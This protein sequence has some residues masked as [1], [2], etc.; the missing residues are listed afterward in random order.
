M[1]AKSLVAAAAVA[2]SAIAFVPAEANAK[3]HWDVHIGVGVPAYPIYEGPAY[4]YEP[5]YPV[6][7]PR[8]HYYEP[9]YT[10]EAPRYRYVER[11]YCG[12]G[13]RAVRDAGFRG[14]D[15][16]DCSGPIFGYTAYR[17][18]DLFKVRVNDSGDIVS[19]RQ[20]D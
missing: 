12:E 8:Y 13:A 3:T 2:A 20:I 16:Y 14:V 19:V 11:S 1:F 5:A 9:T 18:G 7:R 15:A 10:Y 17:H 6:Y 4:V